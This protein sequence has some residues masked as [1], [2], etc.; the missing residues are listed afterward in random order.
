MQGHR[1]LT[2]ICCAA[3]LSLGLAACGGGGSDTTQ[4]PPPVVEPDPVAVEMK[5]INDAIAAAQMAVAVV[6][7]DSDDAVVMAADDAV[8]AAMKAIADA[9]RITAGDVAAANARLATVSGQLA[10]AKSSRT[11]TMTLASERMAISDALAAA[12]AAVGAVADDSDDATVTAAEDAIAAATAAI[13][14]AGH[15]SNSEA[16]TARSEVAAL[17]TSLDAAKSSRQMAMDAAA[18]EERQRKAAEARRNEQLMAITMAI[19]A[20]RT[21]V[22]AVNDA[23]DQ[24]TVDAAN[25][26]VSSAKTK[27]ADAADVSDDVKATHT[28][29]VTAIEGTLT[30]ALASR[31]TAMEASQELADQRTAISTAIAAARTA[32][33]AVNDESTDAQVDAAEKAISDA[34]V[35]IAGAADVPDEEKTANN[36]TLDE[37]ETRLTAAKTSLM[38]AREA[39]DDEQKAANAAMQATAK[40]LHAGLA[41]GLGDTNNVRTGASDADGVIS[42]TIGTDAAVP[43]AED[44]KTMVAANHGWEG[45]RHT[46][47]PTGDVGTY[48]AVVYSNVGDPTEGDPFNEEYTAIDGTTGELALDTADTAVAGRVA[49]SKFDQSAGSKLFKLPGNTVRVMVPGSFHGVSGTYYC[50]PAS[51]TATCTS[52]IA[53]SGFTLTGGAWTFKPSSPTAKVMSVADDT[54]ASYGWW[55]HKSEDGNTY[56][57]SAFATARGTV[58]PAA[59]IDTLRGSAT[60][61]G[62]A[63][64]KYALHSSTGGTND[65]GDFTARAMLEADFNTDTITGTIDTFMDGDGE[66]KDWSVELKKSAIAATGGITGTAADAAAGNQET[67]WTI[68]GTAAAAAG[69]WSGTLYDNGDDGVPKVATGTF[70]SEYGN[71]GRMVGAFGANKQ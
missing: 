52:T 50:T 19:E 54:Y 6:M 32:V 59:G 56:T 7:D 25:A 11:M 21:A 24:D 27:I 43:L 20:A 44:K 51:A 47:E 45:K 34:R 68:D 15:I 29:S 48:E 4:A 39:A 12:M 42:V 30:T 33:A 8:A 14:A 60:Y 18:E 69:E 10:S 17:Q 63:A 66:S 2:M 46:A 71:S 31:M 16:A 61:M 36:G 37:I 26:A 38:A 53:A 58:P 9:T 49:S 1:K 13:G 3:V 40:K 67:V 57:A 70:H 22:A 55:L 28:A 35:A 41:H 65:A 5:A 23:S 62:G 64:G